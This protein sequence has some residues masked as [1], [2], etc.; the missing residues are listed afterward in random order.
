MDKP[1]TMETIVSLAKRRGFVFPSSE[2]YGGFGSTWD[3]GPLGTELKR[4]VKNAWWRA[5][6]QE[7][8]DVVGL[9]SAIL[10]SPLIWQ[11]SGHI[12]TFTDPLVDCTHCK[13]RW[14]ADQVPV[15]L[16]GE[17]KGY[18]PQPGQEALTAVPVCP[19]CGSTALTEPR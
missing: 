15:M 5:N 1:V 9:D 11:A 2:I 12:A 14:R 8:D 3:Y 6:V 16:V 19:N 17:I 10:M 7:R 13:M 18:K 4:N